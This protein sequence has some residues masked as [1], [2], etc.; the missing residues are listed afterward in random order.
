MESIDEKVEEITVFETM[1]MME[2]EM[3]VEPRKARVAVVGV[4]DLMK[5]LKTRRKRP[6]DKR[7]VK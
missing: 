5:S 2:K 1:A 3:Q 7:K 6:I 4:A